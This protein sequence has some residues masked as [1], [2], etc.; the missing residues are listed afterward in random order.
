MT[1]KRSQ[2]M[3]NFLASI[4]TFSPTLAFASCSSITDFKNFVCIIVD[5]IDQLVPVVASLSLLVFLWGLAKFILKSGNEDAVEEGK[6]LMIWGTIALFVM[7]CI[8]GILSFFYG[9]F[10]L[11]GVFGIPQL[12]TN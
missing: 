8:W 6:N 1:K 4:S 11:S 5:L 10:G 7:I 9:D 3:F 12:P 2:K